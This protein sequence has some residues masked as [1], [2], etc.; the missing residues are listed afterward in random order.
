MCGQVKVQLDHIKIATITT[1]ADPQLNILQ[2][3]RDEWYASEPE[4]MSETVIAANLLDVMANLPL[5]SDR[6]QC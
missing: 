1:T 4:S 3:R 6:D 5:S 2:T